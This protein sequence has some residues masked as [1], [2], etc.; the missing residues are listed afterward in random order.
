MILPSWY[1]QTNKLKLPISNLTE[2]FIVT[3]SREVLK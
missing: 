1:R 3:I 2:K